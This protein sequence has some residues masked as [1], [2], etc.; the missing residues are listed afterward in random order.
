MLKSNEYFDG[1]VK[2]VALT[3][4]DGPATVGV[5]S[6]GE[7]EFST[8]S[9]EY[10]TVLNGELNVLFPDGD[11]WVIV[12]QLETFEVEPNATFKVKTD[13]DIAYMCLYTESPIA[14]FDEDDDCDRGCS[15][16]CGS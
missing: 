16:S 2:S 12:E 10:M 13:T 5:I 6:P 1:R 14:E 4:E 15:C 11:D 7:Y 8:T 9:Y 3:T